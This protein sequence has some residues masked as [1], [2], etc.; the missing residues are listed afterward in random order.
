[1][2][3]ASWESQEKGCKHLGRSTDTYRLQANPLSYCEPHKP[4][5]FSTRAILD[6]CVTRDKL[7]VPFPMTKTRLPLLFQK[8]KRQSRMETDSMRCHEFTSYRYEQDDWLYC[9]VILRG[10]GLLLDLKAQNCHDGIN[11]SL[12]RKQYFPPFSIKQPDCSVLV[13]QGK[14]VIAQSGWRMGTCVSVEVDGECM[15]EG[16]PECGSQPVTPGV[17]LNHFSNL[18]SLFLS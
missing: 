3:C 15:G 13:L 8:Y 10:N 7:R 17:F 9:F 6:P 2:L 12:N 5:V 4:R 14:Y 1:M 16:R 18:A 11:I